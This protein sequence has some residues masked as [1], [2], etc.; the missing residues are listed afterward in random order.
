[1]V[2]GFWL[3]NDGLPLQ[4]GTQKVIPELGGDYL[5]WGENREVE[6]LINL[7]ATSFGNGVVQN[8]GLPGTTFSGTST[9]NAAGIVSMTTL[10]PLQATAV[11]G[12]AIP[13]LATSAGILNILQPHLFIDQIDFDVLVAATAGTGGATGLASLGLVTTNPN[14]TPATFVQVTPNGSTAFMGA[15]TNAKMAVGMHYTWYA[16]GSAFGTGTPPTAGSWLGNV[17][18]VTNAIT[19]LPTNGFLSAL[20]TGGPYTG[21]NAGGLCKLRVRYHYYGDINQ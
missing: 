21:T 19:P 17:P 2:S 15:A 8:P 3:N 16:D 9:P 10:F 5:L 4:F 14:V 11:T 6:W 12:D 1:M 7:G 13:P 18:A 20:T